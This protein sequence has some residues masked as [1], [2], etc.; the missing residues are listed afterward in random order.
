M[1][2]YIKSLAIFVAMNIPLCSFAYITS[3]CQLMN[4]PNS[5]I[6]WIFAGNQIIWVTFV[7]SGPL[8]VTLSVACPTIMQGPENYI[9]LPFKSTSEKR[10]SIFGNTPIGWKFELST[11][12]DVALI[13]GH[14]KFEPY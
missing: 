10:Y 3:S 12:T 11:I 4:P 5:F 13:S 8:G 9:I 6:N 14:A 2:K 1:K 7:N